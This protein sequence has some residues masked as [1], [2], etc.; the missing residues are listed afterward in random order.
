MRAYGTTTVYPAR[1]KFHTPC[2]ESIR[3][4]RL[5]APRQRCRTSRPAHHHRGLLFGHATQNLFGWFGQSRRP[6]EV[7]QFRDLGYRPAAVF[8][9]F[10]GVAELATSISLAIGAATPLGG[11][12]TTATSAQ[13][14]QSAKW[15][16]GPWEQDGGY[17]YLLLLGTTG[18]SLAFIGP[19]RHSADARRGLDHSGLVAGIAS[20]ATA[21]IS[22]ALPHR[23]PRMG[24]ADET[25]D[26]ENN[27][28]GNT[29][30]FQ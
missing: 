20:V 29:E 30:T 22:L 10:A 6:P 1:G 16:N 4:P 3:K 7:E 21:A 26:S 13:A 9:R 17:E 23:L 28:T 15:Q 11:A 12:L 14:I 25:T 2:R 8:A 5:D 19:G 18:A 24:D 27:P